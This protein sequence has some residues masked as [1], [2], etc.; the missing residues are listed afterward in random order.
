MVKVGGSCRV[1]S[2][3]SSPRRTIAVVGSGRLGALRR[4]TRQPDHRPE[5]DDRRSPA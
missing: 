5:A 2:Q 3:P 1:A 4:A